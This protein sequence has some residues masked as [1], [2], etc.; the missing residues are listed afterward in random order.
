M[1]NPQ[2]NRSYEIC[3]FGLLLAFFELHGGTDCS[4]GSTHHSGKGLGST[5]NDGD[6]LLNGGMDVRKVPVEFAKGYTKGISD[7][8]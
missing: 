3:E 1:K 4:E 8:G 6:P 5:T 7:Q 2:R